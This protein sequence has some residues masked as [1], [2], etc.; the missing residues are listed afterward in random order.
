MPMNVVSLRRY[1]VKS[2]GGEA[3]D[4]VPLDERGIAGDR[5]FAV[6]DAD[7]HFASGKRTR[8]F[9]RRDAVF[10][11]SAAT[12]RTGEV[13]VKGSSG[14]W[15]IGDPALDD[16]LSQAM[17]AA[18]R[19]TPEADVP[20]HDMGAVSMIGTATLDWCADRWG[21][22]PDPRRLRVNVVFSSTRPFI[23]EE[24]VGQTISVG[25]AALHVIGPSPRCRMIDIAQDGALAE[26]RWLK[27]L[28][29]E[30][31]MFLAMYADVASAG[32]LAVGDELFVT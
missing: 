18:V 1:P 27:L 29:A 8:R 16:E 15:K 14:V 5:W 9:R 30:R 2:M 4:S 26:G 11:Y 21:I 22:N 3:L 13:T 32:V 28:A 10:G 17:G 12:N 6:E 7:G 25:G 31:D 20:H 24:W 19:V 23:E